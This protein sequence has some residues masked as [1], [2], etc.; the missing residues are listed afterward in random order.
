ML[1]MKSCRISSSLDGFGMYVSLPPHEKGNTWESLP[2]LWLALLEGVWLT[3]PSLRQGCSQSSVVVAQKWSLLPSS[4]VVCLHPQ[5]IQPD[6]ENMGN[7]HLFQQG[8]DS[9]CSF[10]NPSFLS[11]FPLLLLPAL[12]G[13]LWCRRIGWMTHFMRR[14]SEDWSCFVPGYLQASSRG[15]GNHKVPGRC[16]IHSLLNCPA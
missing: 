3:S 5:I 9:G 4:P 8:F 15:K 11:P 12:L 14:Q 7:L 2:F 6:L 1:E 10:L 16:H 13:L